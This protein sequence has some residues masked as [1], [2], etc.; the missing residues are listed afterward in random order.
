LSS[1][2]RTT[3]TPP[4]SPPPATRA[5]ISHPYLLKTTDLGRTWTSIVDG[6]AADV[7]TRVVRADPK[8]PG[9]LYCGTET[10]ILVSHDDGGSW[11]KLGGNFPVVP[12]HDLQ[13]RNDDLVVATHGRSFWVLDDLSLIR[14][15]TSDNAVA[16]ANRLFA[17][18]DTYRWASMF[19]FGHEPVPGQNYWFAATQVP[20]LDVAKKPDG[21]LD[22][23]F[24]DAG[25]N[26][27]DGV[28][29]NYLLDGD[30]QPVKLTIL[31]EAGAELRTL[32]SKPPKEKDEETFPPKARKMR[33][34]VRRSCRTSAA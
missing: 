4:T 5:T 16:T 3:A 26:P 13:I 15:A 23:R 11:R 30:D 32:R 28:I 17:P 29:V 14:Q 24:L 31:D 8:Q 12:V 25:T 2:R 18:R 33:T 34:R 22:K 1:R 9:L 10:G 20:S 19:S 7:F 21:T 6:I 27:P